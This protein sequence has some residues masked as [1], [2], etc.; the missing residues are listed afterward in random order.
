MKLSL[1]NIN[2][3]RTPA[4]GALWRLVQASRQGS[5]SCASLSEPAASS[6][7]ELIAPPDARQAAGQLIHERA[8]TLLGLRVQVVNTQFGK[9]RRALGE[10]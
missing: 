8:L 6:N 2:R 7:V 1:L 4:P 9:V 5:R 10:G 3:C